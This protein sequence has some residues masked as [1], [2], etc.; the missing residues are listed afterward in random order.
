MAKSKQLITLLSLRS[1]SLQQAYCWCQYSSRN[2]SWKEMLMR[3]RES[4][5]EIVCILLISKL[6]GIR[7]MTQPG[8]HCFCRYRV[9]NAF[10][11][12]LT[13]AGRWSNDVSKRSWGDAL[14]Q[15]RTGSDRSLLPVPRA[16]ESGGWGGWGG[17]APRGSSSFCMQN[18]AKYVC[19]KEM[20]PKETL[21]DVCLSCQWLLAN[22]SHMMAN[23]ASYFLI[24]TVYCSPWLLCA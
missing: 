12:T 4:E 21:E 8:H 23:H 14:H 11:G 16:A 5:S 2:L 22:V 19:T 6:F 20:K 17:W 18:Q 15:W 10:D 3:E 7:N 24:C 13:V 1:P 9:Q